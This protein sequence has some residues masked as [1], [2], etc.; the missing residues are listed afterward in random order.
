VL[1]EAVLVA[2]LDRIGEAFDGDRRSDCTSALSRPMGSS[3]LHV[4]VRTRSKWMVEST[5]TLG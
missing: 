1:L 5:S 2:N 4:A 3:F